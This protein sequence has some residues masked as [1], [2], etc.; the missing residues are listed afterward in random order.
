MVP[1][2]TNWPAVLDHRQDTP[3]ELARAAARLAAAGVTPDQVR[4]ALADRGSALFAA[5]ASA[6]EGWAEEF[7]GLLGVALLATEVS[8]DAAYLN[9]RAARVRSH[10]VALLL[11]DYSAV[12][13]AQALG[14][15]RQKVYEIGRAYAPAAAIDCAGGRR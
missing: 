4:A 3:D 11:E 9:A 13:V 12:T 8:A 14:V 6:A 2:D 10:S 5:A 1:S 7:A 15:S